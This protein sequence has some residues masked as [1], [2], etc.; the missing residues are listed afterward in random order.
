[1]PAG[2]VAVSAAAEPAAMAEEPLRKLVAAT[3]APRASR[4]NAAFH[5]T[6]ST[7]LRWLLPYG[8]KASFHRTSLQTMGGVEPWIPPLQ[9]PC[10]SFIFQRN[11]LRLRTTHRLGEKKVRAAPEVAPRPARPA[12]AATAT[13]SSRYGGRSEQDREL[14]RDPPGVGSAR[15]R[16]SLQT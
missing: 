10:R 4:L 15:E 6:A 2:A 9:C 7:H 12:G 8:T 11:A 14:E 13:G 1:M 5:P 16:N 3:A